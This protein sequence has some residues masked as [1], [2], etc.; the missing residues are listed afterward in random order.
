MYYVET[1]SV[2]QSV[3]SC[4]G[5]SNSILPDPT[6]RHNLLKGVTGFLPA[7]SM[8]VDR[9]AQN[10]A[11]TAPHTVFLS[12]CNLYRSVHSGTTNIPQS[13][14]GHIAMPAIWTTFCTDVTYSRMHR[15]PSFPH[16]LSDLGEILY[17][18]TGLKIVL[19]K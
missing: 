6:K 17:S 9:S 2:R 14:T 3:R 12:H 11:Q 1:T 19:S 8:P 4:S 15:Y 7:H 5:I 18:R 10:S 13:P 16:L